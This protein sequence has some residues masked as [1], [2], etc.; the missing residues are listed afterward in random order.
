VKKG[1]AQQY[2]DEDNRKGRYDK[3]I[4]TIKGNRE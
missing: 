1:D 2:K 3:K 4:D